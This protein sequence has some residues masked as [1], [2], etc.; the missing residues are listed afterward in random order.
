LLLQ[1]IHSGRVG[2]NP[3]EQT[4]FTVAHLF[5]LPVS[6][7]E[8]WENGS[9]E[10]SNSQPEQCLVEHRSL[11]RLP[12]TQNLFLN[13]DVFRTSFTL[14][15]FPV[16]A[17]SWIIP[18]IVAGE[19]VGADLG[20]VEQAFV[21]LRYLDKLRSLTRIIICSSFSGVWVKFFGSLEVRTFD[22]LDC[23]IFFDAQFNVVFSVEESAGAVNTPSGQY[24][25][26]LSISQPSITY[27]SK[28]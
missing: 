20:F 6:Y 21:R 8:S 24:S 4:L 13:L 17:L 16:L 28:G 11:A 15:D 12:L 26:H 14:S 22:L 7:E 27:L 2:S 9:K 25:H 18:G 23:G 19:A 3:F 10:D 1:H 5:I